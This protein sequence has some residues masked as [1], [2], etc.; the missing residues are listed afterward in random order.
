ML[1]M[2]VMFTLFKAAQPLKHSLF[3]E[4]MLGSSICS[5]VGWPSNALK[6]RDLNFMSMLLEMMN[7]FSFV[8]VV[9]KTLF[10]KSFDSSFPYIASTLLTSVTLDLCIALT[11]EFP[12]P[13]ITSFT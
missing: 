11:S 7:S 13:S 12:V 10:P 6:G 9:V 3:I 1:E 2:L 4:T 5:S 8:S